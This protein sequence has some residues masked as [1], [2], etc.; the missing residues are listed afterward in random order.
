MKNKTKLATI[1]LASLLL[2][3]S[4]PLNTLANEEAVV[5]SIAQE[6]VITLGEKLQNEIVLNPKF[7]ALSKVLDGF[8]YKEEIK[9]NKIITTA[10]IDVSEIEKLN[11]NPDVINKIMNS[12]EGGWDLFAFLFV[13]SLDATEETDSNQI[14]KI[15]EHLY[16]KDKK[17]VHL[18][19]L[20]I[21]TNDDG[22]IVK[23]NNIDIV[24]LNEQTVQQVVPYTDIQGHWAKEHIDSLSSKGIFTKQTN[25]N[26]NK[27]ITRAQF[28]A[29][30]SRTM[31]NTL[32]HEEP[33]YFDI[34][35]SHWASY[36]IAKLVD[37]YILNA[38]NQENFNPNK[39]ITR[40]QAALMMYRYLNLHAPANVAAVQTQKTLG[41]FTD[42]KDASKEVQEAVN[43]LVALNVL[44]GKGDK[45]D[46]H[47]NLT[48]AQMAK[49]LDNVLQLKIEN[50]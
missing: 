39:E 1:T 41:Q 3:Q 14:V 48:R 10:K 29:M 35:D 19:T 42:M 31:P 20:S 46:L 27:S 15:E 34:E 37:T 33:P 45:F 4:L 24:K 36:D 38:S 44:N 8:T 18:N 11:D 7:Y 21:K 22:E 13:F 30:L 17:E 43:T 49:I 23:S 32:S 6:D 2:F 12:K 26:P 28:A 5:T 25:F 47:S 40:Q 9:G 16:D 50:R